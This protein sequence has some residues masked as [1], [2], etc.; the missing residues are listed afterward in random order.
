MNKVNRLRFIVERYGPEFVFPFFVCRTWEEIA[1]AIVSFESEG[2]MWGIRT[3]YPSM[4]RLGFSLPFIPHANAKQ[5]EELWQQHRDRLVYII[6]NTMTEACVNAV[7][8]RLDAEHVLFEYN[9]VDIFL[10]Q[11]HMYNHPRNLRQMIVGPH[12]S[13]RYAVGNSFASSFPVFVLEDA[14][15]QDLHFPK[16]YNLFLIHPDEQEITF[17]VRLRTNQI[18]IW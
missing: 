2:K 4:Q 14:R 12:R 5:A 17:S 10:T 7:A 3:D 9:P 15:V 6:Y 11:R 18:I 8:I 13:L 1:K 16:M